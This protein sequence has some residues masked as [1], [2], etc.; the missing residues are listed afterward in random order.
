MN[1]YDLEEEL[2][3]LEELEETKE[4]KEEADEVEEPNQTELS[5]DTPTADAENQTANAPA[6]TDE[7]DLPEPY[8]EK[9]L[10]KKEESMVAAIFDYVEIFAISLCA[11]VLLFSVALRLCRVNGS[12]MNQTLQNGEVLLISDLF[13]QPQNGD[14]IVFHQTGTLNEPLVKRVIATG[15]QTVKIDFLNGITYVDGEVFE[16]AYADDTYVYLGGRNSSLLPKKEQKYNYGPFLQENGQYI[17]ADGCYERTV[18]E[19]TV[20]VMGDNRNDSKDSR[21]AD[22]GFVDERRILG[23]VFLR[24]SPFTVFD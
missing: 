9:P 13:Y 19:G 14:I 7:S 20:F 22:V 18:P 11:V 2:E 23:K 12:S 16:D 6:P 1:D 15:G 10:P 8:E 24:L 5:K 17:T 4:T 3:E 21:Y